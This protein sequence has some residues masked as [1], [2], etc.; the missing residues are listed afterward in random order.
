MRRRTMVIIRRD[1]HIGD[2]V[3]AIFLD[4]AA[5]GGDFI[6]ERLRD[7]LGAKVK[8]QK[9]E[10]LSDRVEVEV[11][12]E[13]L[14][15]ESRRLAGAAN[16]LRIH[17]ARRNAQALFKEALELDPLNV[18]ATVGMG[19]AFA[20]RERYADA[21]LTLKRAREIGARDTAE[22]LL[23]LARVCLKVDR[24]ASAIVYLERAYEIEPGNFA[25]RRLLA[26]LGRK[27][28]PPAKHSRG[29][30][31]PSRKQK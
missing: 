18:E 17:G 8:I 29:P 3:G 22:L 28:A 21:L 10:M 5:P 4:P 31:R 15:D 24:M 1:D 14:S 7:Y 20:A 30:A 12:V 13:A 25:V 26:Q 23:A 19:L 16:E 27:P 9:A 2:P 11:E 6:I